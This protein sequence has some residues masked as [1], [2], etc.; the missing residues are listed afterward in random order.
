MY[1]FAACDKSVLADIWMEHIM[2]NNVLRYMS[3]VN[4]CQDVLSDVHVPLIVLCTIAVFA[5]HNNVKTARRVAAKN[6]SRHTRPRLRGLWSKCLM[7]LVYAVFNHY[8][9]SSC[10]LSCILFAD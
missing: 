1:P 6:K 2:N 7:T 9:R 5:G 4:Y 8:R 10:I 3:I